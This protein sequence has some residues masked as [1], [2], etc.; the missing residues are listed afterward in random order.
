MKREKR[1]VRVNPRNGAGRIGGRVERT[2]IHASA[3]RFPATRSGGV[4]A[5]GC[6]AIAANSSSETTLRR[7]I[8]VL[9]PRAVIVRRADRCDLANS[10]GADQHGNLTGP[11]ANLAGLG[12]NLAGLGANL[13]GLGADLAG[14]GASLVGLGAS[15]AVAV[16][17]ADLL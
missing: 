4:S 2:R 7:A 15:L 6:I 9:V 12:V 14:P 3:S 1:S 17:E 16:V 10:G 11:G 8:A 13:A 5:I